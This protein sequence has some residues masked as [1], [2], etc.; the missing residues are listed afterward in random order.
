MS[1]LR[2]EKVERVANYIPDLEIEGD[3]D[4]DVLVVSWG[5]TYGVMLTAIEELR[6]EGKKVS[7]AHFRYIKPMP[8][9]T[10]EVFSK[11]KKIIVCEINLG[12]FVN[13]LRMQFPSNNYQQYN[14][15]QGL[16]FTVA[17]LKDRFVSLLN[18]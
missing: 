14:K 7:L 1:Y 3:E 11:F 15:I 18:E 5:G 6:A 4:G 17:E 13:Y 10:A 8:K 9:N 16:P 12:Q 2:E